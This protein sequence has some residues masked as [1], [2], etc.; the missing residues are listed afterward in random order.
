MRSLI[1]QVRNLD[2]AKPLLVGDAGVELLAR[3]EPVGHAR[4]PEHDVGGARSLLRGTVHGATSDGAVGRS[5]R[6]DS[7]RVGAG[8]ACMGSLG[9]TPPRRGELEGVRRR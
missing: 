7:H 8:V 4:A 6:G 5:T 1:Q 3:H 9:G 2:G